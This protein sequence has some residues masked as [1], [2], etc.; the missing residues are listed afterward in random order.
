MSVDQILNEIERMPAR[1]FARVVEGVHAR[2]GSLIQAEV[3]RRYEEL[4]SGKVH[5]LT[6]EEIFARIEERLK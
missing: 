3:R 6:R 5:G 2:E 4:K 1:E